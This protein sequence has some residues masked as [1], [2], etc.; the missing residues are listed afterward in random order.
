MR[1]Q[2]DIIFM[3]RCLELA[4]KA[5][6]MTYPNPL[7]GSVIVH[8]GTIAGEGYHIK[9]GGPH[10]EVIAI[11][12]V[13]D[14]R[15]LR[16]SSIYVNLE[17]CSH[18]GK[19]PP[20]TDL[21]ISSRIPRV[22]A[23]AIDTSDKVSGKGLASLRDAGCEVISGVLNEECRYLNRR[24]FTFHEKRRPYITLKWAQ[25]SDGFLD[26]IR[27]EGYSVEPNWI[28]GKPEKVLVHKWRAA[29]QAILIGAGTARSDNPRL[30]VREWSGNDPIRIIL[31]G[32]GILPD[33][34]ALNDP[35]GNCIIFTHYPHK[36]NYKSI[37]VV[38][39]N[40]E[41]TAAGQISEY[42][43]KSG[44][45]SLF[46][47]GGL[48]VLEHFISTGFWDEARVFYG[49]IPFKDGIRAPEINGEIISQTGFSQSLLKVFVNN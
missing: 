46:I 28:T 21:I 25:S 33:K 16:T 45:Q 40:K 41:G 6:G 3:K 47:E 11:N 4:A 7:A 49:K 36:I 37:D 42:L 18:F 44:I 35:P 22:V 19:T 5:E 12:S 2:D 14:K 17:P 13:G 15:N 32:S 34:L 29:E 10:A 23:G 1:E 31:T 39:L 8:N 43:F 38:E 24:F 27:H 48:N 30:N 20:C 26:I 9:A